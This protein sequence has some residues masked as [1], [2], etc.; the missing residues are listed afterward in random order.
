MGRYMRLAFV[1]GPHGRT[2][3]YDEFMVP[4]SMF[5]SPHPPCGLQGSRQVQVVKSRH[6]H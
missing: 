5:S 4:W 1:T 6:Q 3:L 2:M